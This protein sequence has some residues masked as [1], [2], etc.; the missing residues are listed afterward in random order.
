MV[1]PADPR[2]LQYYDENA[3][4]Y[5]ANTVGLDVG[6]LRDRFLKHV[7]A[8]AR[9]LDAGSGSGRDTLAFLQRGYA[10]EAFDA[11]PNLAAL[12]SRLTGLKTR[13]LRLEDFHDYLRFD[14]I[15]ACASLVHVPLA[16]MNVV[17]GQLRQA[18]RSGGVLYVSFKEGHDETISED[19]RRFTNFDSDSLR[20]L[21]KHAEF[22]V[23]DVWSSEGMK[24]LG[25]PERWI[26]AIA[27]K[28]TRGGDSCSSS[29]AD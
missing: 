19:G 7:P 12:S 17:L 28:P 22:S 25:S 3:D 6:P 16:S 10:V 5:F 13:V 15:W 18:L 8:N 26:N 21:L 4:L 24:A 11:S 20:A 9:L 14:G 27:V 2:T 23:P 1:V 29:S